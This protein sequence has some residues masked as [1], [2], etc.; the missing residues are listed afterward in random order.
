MDA[1]RTTAH[2]GATIEGFDTAWRQVDEKVRSMMR[3]MY[4]LIGLSRLG[5]HPVEVARF[6]AYLDRTADEAIALL[7]DSGGALFTPRVD[8]GLITVDLDRPVALRRPA[9][10]DR[11]AADRDEWLCT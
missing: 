9:P 8:D 10:S 5:E 1:Q 4:G 2:D 7:D 11:P 3:V 6:A